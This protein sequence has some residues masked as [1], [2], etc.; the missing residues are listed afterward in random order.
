[1]NGEHWFRGIDQELVSELVRFENDAV[2]TGDF[3]AVDVKIRIQ[4]S[5]DEAN[6]FEFLMTTT[7][8]YRYLGYYLPSKEEVVRALLEPME[9][10]FLAIVEE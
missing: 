8:A 7:S 5:M 2:V 9:I 6:A 1:D 3:G 10:S 4:E